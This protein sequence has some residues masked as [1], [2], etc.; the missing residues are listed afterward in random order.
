MAEKG[1]EQATPLRKKKARD[2]GDSVH[3]RELLSA[4]AMLGGVMTL[5]ALSSRFVSSWG[6][7]YA[8]SVSSAMV[9]LN[10]VGRE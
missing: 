5:G 8:E 1:T 6:R 2:R 4:M 9:G 10:G 7:V 3:S